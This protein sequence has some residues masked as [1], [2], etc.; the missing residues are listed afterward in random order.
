MLCWRFIQK[1]NLYVGD[2]NTKSSHVGDLNKIVGGGHRCA[3]A[4]GCHINPL[5]QALELMYRYTTTPL[6]RQNF[7]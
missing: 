6:P 1:S 7:D 5:A 2:S 4:N 3:R